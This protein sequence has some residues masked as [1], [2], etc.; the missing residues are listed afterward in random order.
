MTAAVELSLAAGGAAVLASGCAIV[1]VARTRHSRSHIAWSA[2]SLVLAGAVFGL[3][4][5]VVVVMT[6]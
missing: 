1:A 4:L 5:G 3:A 6:R 2:A